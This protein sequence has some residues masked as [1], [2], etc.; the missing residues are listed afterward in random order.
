MQMVPLN[1]WMLCCVADLTRGNKLMIWLIICSQEQKEI[2]KVVLLQLNV[3]NAD[4]R[5]HF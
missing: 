4:L 3:K 5:G 1:I 2:S